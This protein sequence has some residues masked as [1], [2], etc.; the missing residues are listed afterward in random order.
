VSAA[1]ASR[2]AV[3]ETF[4][5]RVAFDVA[6]IRRF[7]AQ[8]GDFNPLHHDEDV[9]KAGPYGTIIASGTHPTALLMG[10]TATHFSKRH[11]PLGLEFRFRFVRAVPA[12]VTL[13]LR[14]TVVDVVHKASLEGDIV[15][16][17]GSASD[18]DRTLYTSGEAKILIRPPIVAGGERKS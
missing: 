10:L 11:Q 9:A 7:A 6:S 5:V 14:W 13:D 15:T 8:C 17:D 18:D 16:L 3:G 1:G 2:V 12:G 4:A